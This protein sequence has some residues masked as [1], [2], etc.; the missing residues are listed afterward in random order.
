MRSKVSGLRPTRHAG[1]KAPRT[2]DPLPWRFRAGEPRPGAD[3]T[4]DTHRRLRS[5]W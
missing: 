5:T 3:R 2:P 1:A 4:R